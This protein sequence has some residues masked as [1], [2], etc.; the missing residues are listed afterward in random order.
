MEHAF[1]HHRWQTNQIGFHEPDVNQLLVKHLGKLAL[2]TGAR[3]FVPLCGKTRDIGWLLSQGLRVV[4]AELSPLAVQQLF[5]D[6]EL[7]P[8]TSSTGALQLSRAAGLDVFVGDIFTLSA[9]QL[10]VVDAVYDRAALVALPP[11]LRQQYA[12]HIRAISHSAPQLVITFDYD[13]QIMPGPPFSISDAEL[14]DHYASTFELSLLSSSSVPGGLK[15]QCPSLEKTW[16]LQ[17]R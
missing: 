10:G 7:Q 14:N 12:R 8:V 17:P 4:G 11:E 5:A 13:Q 9:D 16:L 3:V 6:L 15:N 2:P 1:W